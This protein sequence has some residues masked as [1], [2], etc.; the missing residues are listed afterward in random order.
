MHFAGHRGGKTAD[1][2][3][4]AF[5]AGDLQKRVAVERKDEHFVKALAGRPAAPDRIFEIDVFAVGGKHELVGIFKARFGAFGPADE[6]E[7]FPFPFFVV[8]AEK[9]TELTADLRRVVSAG[10]IE[11]E[12]LRE[13]CFDR[14]FVEF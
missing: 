2:Q 10:H 8:I 5:G 12:R 14:I 9:I 1:L 11:K 6:S 4:D 13:I 7:K 3:P